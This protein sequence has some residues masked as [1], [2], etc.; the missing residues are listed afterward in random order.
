MRN[1]R[2]SDEY[3]KIKL[4]LRP[5]EVV[6]M[7][8]IATG[9]FKLVI[10]GV[11]YKLQL[12]HNAKELEAL[13][14]H[15]EILKLGW[16]LPKIKSI[17]IIDTID[18][19]KHIYTLTEWWEGVTGLEYRERCGRIPESFYEKL[20]HWVG[21]LHDVVIDG[22]HISVLNYWPRNCLIRDNGDV[23]YL[24]LNKLYFTEHRTSWF[25]KCIVSETPTV[26]RK[27]ANA[28]LATYRQHHEYDYKKVLKWYLE[29]VSENWHD[30]IIDGKPFFPGK[31]SFL[32]RWN[33]LNL[34]VDL[35]GKC[36]LDLG[37]GNGMFALEAAKRG[38]KRVYAIDNRFVNIGHQ[39]Y[40]MSDYGKLL[41]VYHGYNENNLLYKHM[42]M[43]TDW[44]IFN[45]MKEDLAYLPDKK[46]DIVFAMGA[47]RKF[48][49]EKKGQF[50]GMLQNIGE[51]IIYEP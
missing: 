36:V 41:C 21:K 31:S 9:A 22:K 20:G 32:K 35:S 30:V 37:Y 40:R 5:G 24:D 13:H 19:R 14:I 45:H 8:A 3:K 28:F 39:H 38:A 48:T 15:Q 26:D 1:W 44:F 47:D 16:D 7:P 12:R 51:R 33:D 27:Q 4:A 11:P 49:D 29:N 34:P 18:G 10:D 23:V 50:K 25:E 46:W 43:D 17:R 6:D 2:E 42:D